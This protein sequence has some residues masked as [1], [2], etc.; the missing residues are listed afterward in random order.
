MAT[1]GLGGGRATFCG[2]SNNI[3]M[4]PMK[5]RNFQRRRPTWSNGSDSD[6][7][8]CEFFFSFSFQTK[9]VKKGFWFSVL[10]TIVFFV[11]D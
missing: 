10:Q 9:K 7:G 5:S 3:C 2:D 4:Y 6:S 1:P 11:I 8:G